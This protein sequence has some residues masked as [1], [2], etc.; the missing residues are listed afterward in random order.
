MAVFLISYDDRAPHDYSA[1]YKLLSL[2]DAKRLLESL[3][4][5]ELVGPAETICNLLFN[6]LGVND[7]VSVFQVSPN[8][9]GC[10]I[11]ANPEGVD[12]LIRRAGWRRML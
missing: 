12:L 3:W 5:A 8:C 4:V 2:W 9:D 7:G 11:G 6:T 10:T 1:L